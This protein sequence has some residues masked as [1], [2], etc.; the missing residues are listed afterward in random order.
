MG[1]EKRGWIAGVECGFTWNVPIAGQDGPIRIYGRPI[2]G[3]VGQGAESLAE[4]S[5]DSV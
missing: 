3:V 1:F 2:N 5:R 4:G